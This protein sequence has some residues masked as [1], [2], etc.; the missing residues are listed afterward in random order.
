MFKSTN[1]DVTVKWMSSTSLSDATLDLLAAD[2]R[3]SKFEPILAMEEG[4]EYYE[5]PTLHQLHSFCSEEENEAAS[6][7]YFHSKTKEAERVAM[8]EY[9][10]DECGKI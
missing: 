2:P 10:F 4:E 6:V 9:V 3:K 8:E 5:Y 7:F 1:L